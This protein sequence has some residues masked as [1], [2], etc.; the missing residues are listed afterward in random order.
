VLDWQV[1]S[2][3]PGFGYVLDGDQ[4]RAGLVGSEIYVSAVL[5]GI[6]GIGRRFTLRLEK[7]L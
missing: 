4:W 7:I 2:R 5:S 6:R 3:E 1:T